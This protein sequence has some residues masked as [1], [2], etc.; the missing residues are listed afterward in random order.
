MSKK[1]KPL[2]AP[3]DQILIL[4]KQGKI[5][6]L[7][8]DFKFPYLFSIKLDG[9]RT[10]F[11]DGQMLTC[12]LKQVPN[13]QLQ[14]Q[15]EYLKKYSK[16]NNVILDGE[17]FSPFCTF[18]EIISYFMT[19]DFED[20]KSIKKF[21]EVLEIPFHLRFHCFDLIKC[22][23]ADFKTRQADLE[24]I[25]IDLNQNQDF[26]YVQHT[27]VNNLEELEQM[28]YNALNEG[29]EGLM[30][31]STTG[32]YKYGRATMRENIIYKMKP[33]QTF[34]GPI[35]GFVQSTEVNKTAEK[36]KN[37][38][39][40]SV[41][42]KKKGDRHTIEKCSAVFVDYEGQQLKVTLA[43]TDKEKE[44]LWKNQDGYLNRWIEYKAMSVGMKENGLPR[45]PVFI[46]FREDK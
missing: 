26:I 24:S 43:M 30:L 31:R 29:H 16:D 13:K 8:N 36:K 14:E 18:Q 32:K 4:D 38:M 7:W 44:Q 12:S 46:R 3:N 19:Q 9:C 5:N 40:Y 45:H 2:K 37:E 6:W 11:K 35:T 33:F 1:F 15:F 20:K 10:I 25:S 42:S 23:N 28:F 41:T 39:G 17:I 22:P 27:L 21:G 34:D